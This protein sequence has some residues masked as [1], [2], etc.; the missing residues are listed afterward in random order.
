MTVKSLN[1]STVVRHRK[2]VIFFFFVGVYVRGS[3]PDFEYWNTD[4]GSPVL[5]SLGFPDYERDG[6]HPVRHNPT[7]RL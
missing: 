5:V 6:D 2:R 3:F 7:Y 4:P 1:C